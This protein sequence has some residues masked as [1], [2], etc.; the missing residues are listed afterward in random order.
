MQLPSFPG[1]CAWCGSPASERVY[2]SGRGMSKVY[3]L[4]CAEHTRGKKRYEVNATRAARSRE[5]EILERTEPL[6]QSCGAEI[7]WISLPRN[8][9]R[10]PVDRRPLRVTE[11]KRAMVLVDAKKPVGVVL[12]QSDLDSGAAKRRLDGGARLHLSHHMTCEVVKRARETRRRQQNR[13]AAT[14]A[15]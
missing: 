6:C 2:V 10:M 8:S 3:A 5:P 13:T 14:A 12:K 4:A 11:P 7:T 15:A 1:S 9:K